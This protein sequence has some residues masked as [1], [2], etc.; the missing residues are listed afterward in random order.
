M[1][2]YLKLFVAVFFILAAVRVTKSDTFSISGKVR[3]SDNNQVV[4]T[5]YVKAIDHATGQLVA[6]VPIEPT[7]DYILICVRQI[8]AGTDVIGIAAN[9]PEGDNFVPTLFPDKVNP[10]EATTIYINGNMSN[11]DLKVRRT[12]GGGGYPITSS[13]S[14]LIVNKDNQPVAD[15]I[16]YAKIGNDYYGYGI[17][18][19]KG[20]YVIN[21]IPTGDFILIAHKI[22]NQSD[23]IS[24]T[25]G[26]NGLT[27]VNFVMNK[28]NNNN[29]NNNL[30]IAPEKFNLT[31]N[32]PNPFNPSTT[33]K[34][35]V[36]VNSQ[37]SLKVYNTTGQ[38]VATLAEGMQDAGNYEISFNASNFSSGVYYY[39]LSAGSFTE[40]R[41]MTLIK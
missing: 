23:L 16:V 10:A 29:N 18:D 34:Y 35:S 32:F 13:V 41:K 3:Y 27:N 14:G 11:V 33:I 37:V 19:A 30:T 6:T 1:R 25:I 22:A 7:G 9:E 20:K 26:E 21:N 38:V 4:T 40:T 17:S 39:R 8:G 15:A 5:G 36:P 12:T 28:L 24:V 2:S 31:Q